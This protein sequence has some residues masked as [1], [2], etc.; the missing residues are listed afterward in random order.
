MNPYK[1][2]R[3]NAANLLYERRYGVRTAERVDLEDIGLAGEDR[4]Y[5]AALNW[6]ALRRALPVREVTSQDVFIDFGSGM[7]R[8]IVQAASYPFRRVIGVELSEQLT[9]IARQNVVAMRV[10]RRCGEIELVASDVLE[11]DIPDD[12]TVAFFNNPFRGQI[13]SNVIDRLLV[14]VDRNPRRVRM[15]Y[16]NPAEEEYLLSTGRFEHTGTIVTRRNDPLGPPFGT[17]RTYEVL[18]KPGA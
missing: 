1:W 10:R 2:L 13:F 9:E 7:G 6:R 17:I 8:A 15:V 3:R 12:V 18:P 14:S 5:Y 11:Y 16:G 4:V